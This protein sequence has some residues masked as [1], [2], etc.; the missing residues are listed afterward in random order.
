MSFKDILGHSGVIKRLQAVLLEGSLP[1]AYLFTGPEGVGKGMAARVLAKALNCQEEKPDSC[2][3]CQ[4]CLKIDKMQHPDVWFLDFE[5]S[6]IKI[7][8]IRQ[9]Q[10][11]IS[12]RP[13]EGKKKVFIINNAHNLNAES[14]NA[15]LKTLEEPPKNSVIILVTAKPQLLFPTIV[16]R[17]QTIRFYAFPRPM[18]EN[19]LVKDHGLDDQLAHFLAYYC[20]GSLGEALKFKEQDMLNRKNRIIDGFILR[21]SGLE[22]KT[23]DDLRFGLNIISSW[24]RDLYLMKS[25]ISEDCLINRDRSDE[26]QSMSRG[27]SLAR[28]DSSMNIVSNSFSYVDRNVN[29]KLILSNLKV[30]L[31]D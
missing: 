30:N 20:E 13:Y 19:I 4:S 23:R 3:V 7:E 22:A 17:C 31:K 5:S 15:F 1:G 12:L 2:D 9:L 26:L 28:L 11:D 16:S 29:I 21:D 8:Y 25:G 18:L 14:S 6:E 27:Y 10:R 24:F